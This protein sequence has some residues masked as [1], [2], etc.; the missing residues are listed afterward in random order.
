MRTLIPLLLTM[1]SLALAG[2]AIDERADMAADG[3]VTVINISG[4]IDI[5]TWDEAAVHLTGEL[6]EGS[7]LSFDASGGDV[8]VEV[9]VEDGGRW[10]RG[11]ESSDL[12][13]RV[14]RKA[15]LV[16][17]GVSAD[18]RIDGAGGRMIEAESV[19][20]DVQATGDVER[21]ELTSVSGDVDFRG[22]ARRTVAESV[23][24]DIDLDG[25]EGELEVSLVSGDLELLAGT[26]ELGRFEAV[27]GTLDMAVTVAPGGRLSVETMSGD[28]ILL[29]PAEQ[30][31]VFQAQT[32]SGDIRSVF[33]SPQRS[34]SGSGTRLDHE[35]GEN[36]ASIRLETFSGDVRIGHK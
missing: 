7:E 17:T 33:G 3:T 19:S 25:V 35:T 29:L 24:G 1:P 12:V 32:F 18:V 11:P 14:P 5:S 16:V 2:T 4:E 27:S 6:G 30:Q 31:G 10:G 8:R 26:L 20:G 34:R 28:V 22:S 21:L 15:D 9:K 13:L 36:G 23:S